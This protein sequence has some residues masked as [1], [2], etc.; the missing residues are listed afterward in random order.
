V[1]LV[2]VLDVPILTG[3]SHVFPIKVDVAWLLVHGVVILEWVIIEVHLLVLGT[4][5]A[6]DTYSV[7]LVPHS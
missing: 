3:T 1:Q 6:I 2:D 5:T 4:V 7:L